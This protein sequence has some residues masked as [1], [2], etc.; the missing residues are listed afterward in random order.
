MA[1]SSLLNE[2]AAAVLAV[3][4]FSIANTVL[5]EANLKSQIPRLSHVRGVGE[6]AFDPH[7]LTRAVAGVFAG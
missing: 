3:A 6:D 1:D 7:Q 5:N 4:A 2:K